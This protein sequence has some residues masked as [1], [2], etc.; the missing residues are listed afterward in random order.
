MNCNYQGR[1]VVHIY[2]KSNKDMSQC[3]ASLSETVGMRITNQALPNDIT[4][5]EEVNI[6]VTVECLKP[7]KEYPTIDILFKQGNANHSY[8]FKLP[9][10]MTSFFEAIPS[11]KVTYMSR[12]K[13]LEN[14]VQDI[15]TSS[16]TI[17]SEYLLY[18]R[19]VMFTRLKI[20]LAA[21]LDPTEKT[22]T[23]SF[24]FHTGTTNAEGNYLSIGGMLRLEAD[25]NQGRFRV[26]VRSKH[27]LVSEAIRDILKYFLS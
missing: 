5:G 3:Q 4:S 8:T 12:W 25:I 21:D 16:S 20:G 15:F 7:F 13:V 11:D 18:I 2:N 22:V 9:I 23:G 24:S 19:N 17:N 1:L 14:E 10:I 26:T 27:I 6:Q